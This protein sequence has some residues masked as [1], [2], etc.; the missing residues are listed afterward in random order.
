MEK[1]NLKSIIGFIALALAALFLIKL[2]DLS[3]PLSITT[4]TRSSELSVVGEGKVE[5]IPNVAYVDAGVTVSN[6]AS[7]NEVQ[8]SLNKTNNAILQAVQ[9]LGVKKQDISTSNYSVNPTYSYDNNVDKIS[10]YSGNIT[11]T[12]KVRDTQLVSKILTAVTNVGANQIQ[13]VR[14]EID[15]PSKLREDARNKAIKDAKEQAKRL[16]KTLDIKLGRV[17]NIIESPTGGVPVF[18]QRE[19]AADSM[20]IG[21]APQVEPGTQTVTSTVT[22]FFEKK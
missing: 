13:G 2:F 21:G 9:K 14:F 7:V 18:L 10:G 5:A 16:A 1:N 17:V 6:G 4:T 22:L 15:N 19:F 3:Y 20:G 11:I 12:I 8:G